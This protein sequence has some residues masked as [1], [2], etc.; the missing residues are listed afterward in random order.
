MSYVH[1]NL[2]CGIFG[3]QAWS[4]MKLE[5]NPVQAALVATLSYIL[6]C[7]QG[8]SL[9]QTHNNNEKFNLPAEMFGLLRL[10]GRVSVS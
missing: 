2:Q 1:L 7:P 3:K 8:E 6:P 10:A 4:W 9:S 5:I